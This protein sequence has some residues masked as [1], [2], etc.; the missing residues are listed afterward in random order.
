VETFVLVL[1]CIKPTPWSALW[2]ENGT[3]IWELARE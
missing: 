2:S 3:P 1:N